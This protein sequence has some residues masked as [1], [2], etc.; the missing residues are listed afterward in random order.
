[1]PGNTKLKKRGCQ[2]KNREYIDGYFSM[3]RRE[4]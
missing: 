4:L 1:M 3:T 2:L